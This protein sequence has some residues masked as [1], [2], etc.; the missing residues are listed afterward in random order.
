MREVIEPLT[1][2]AGVRH[3]AVVSGDGVPV[4]VLERDGRAGE[5]IDRSFDDGAK[6]SG[7]RIDAMSF[8]ALAAGWQDELGR[9]I[10]QL[11]WDAP[12]RIVLVATQGTLIL[13]QGPGA[14]V[15][16]VL[17]P[18]TPPESLAIPLDSAVA[19]MERLLRSLGQ[20][21]ATQEAPSLVDP[22]G[23]ADAAEPVQLDV[24]SDPDAELHFDEPAARAL[25]GAPRRGR[26]GRSG[27]CRRRACRAPARAPRRSGC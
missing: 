5:F 15:L 26:W 9:S 6:L 25:Q 10:G 18:G 4:A 19:R 12:W 11:S 24:G 22:T 16:V 1:Q 21:A 20:H 17:D 23:P 27:G 7:Q 14:V 2:V 3:A 8:G 13:Q